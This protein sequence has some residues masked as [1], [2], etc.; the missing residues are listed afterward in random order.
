V[1]GRGET[2]RMTVVGGGSISWLFVVAVKERF[3]SVDVWPPQKIMM[4]PNFENSNSN[5]SARV[6]VEGQTIGRKLWPNKL[7]SF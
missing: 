2:K 6:E 1:E 7:F 4:S 5:G 3:F